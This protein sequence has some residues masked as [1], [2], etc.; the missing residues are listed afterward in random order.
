MTKATI[1]VEA[2]LGNMWYGRGWSPYVEEVEAE[3]RCLT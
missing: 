1:S 2:R 3:S